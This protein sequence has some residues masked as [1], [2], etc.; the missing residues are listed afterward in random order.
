MTGASHAHRVE[1]RPEIGGTPFRDGIN[2]A[3]GRRG[4]RDR[5]Q[6]GWVAA[7]QSLQ[8][9]CR[10]PDVITV[11][12][13]PAHRRAAAGQGQQK[14]QND[15]KQR[16]Q[17]AISVPW[18][19]KA[20]KSVLKGNSSQHGLL[21]SDMAAVPHHRGISSLQFRPLHS[22]ALAVSIIVG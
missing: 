16:Q 6:L 1:Q 11:C 9:E 4:H 18:I 17:P 21:L 8:L 20:G 10:H 2:G 15:R 13:R 3:A 22:G 14:C 5:G 12:Q 19:R 7:L